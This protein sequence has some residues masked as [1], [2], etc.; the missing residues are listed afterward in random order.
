MS[1]RTET[2]INGG[3]SV[4]Q[5]V[6]HVL[7]DPGTSGVPPARDPQIIR[8]PGALS[9]GDHLLTVSEAATV[10]RCSLL[11]VRRA[12][13]AGNLTARRRPASRS[14]LLLRSEVEAWARG[15]PMEPM[16]PLTEL[17]AAQ[18]VSGERRAP[19]DRFVANAE[20]ALRAR[21]RLL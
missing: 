10:A 3:R 5:G 15:E 1:A 4:V 8:Q 9:D 16:A 2:P 18:Q 21:G 13:R 7:A 17:R 6:A 11:T 14:V 20:A 19:R 12:Y